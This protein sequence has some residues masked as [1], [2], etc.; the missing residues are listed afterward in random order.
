MPPLKGASKSVFEVVKTSSVDG[1]TDFE[2]HIALPALPAKTLE[3]RRCGLVERG[4]VQYAGRTRH[5]NGRDHK[6]WIV[7]DGTPHPVPKKPSSAELRA[8]VALLDNRFEASR[9][10]L[11]F[12]AEKKR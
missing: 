10:W 2:I 3:A 7:G 12:Q 6:V 11:L 5:L 4:Y 8:V 1:V 9:E